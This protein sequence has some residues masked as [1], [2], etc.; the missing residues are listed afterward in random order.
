MNS[1]ELM[2]NIAREICQDCGPDRDCE[3]EYSDCTRI[4]N[5]LEWLRQYL[6][7]GG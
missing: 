4:S 7:E 2:Q 3:L 1:V 5:G 6:K